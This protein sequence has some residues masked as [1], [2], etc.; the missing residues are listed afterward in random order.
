MTISKIEGKLALR[1]VQNADIKLDKVFVPE[2]NKLHY[3]LN[4]EKSANL[5]LLES[6]LGVAACACGMAIGV[7]EDCLKYC[8]QRKQ[9]RRPIARFQLVQERLSRMLAN[10]EF[11]LSL[12]LFTGKKI[13]EGGQKLEMG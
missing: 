4:F 1:M 11:M 3:A 8:L 5:V 10:C 12:L 2:K 13:D 7:Y 6:R 9:F